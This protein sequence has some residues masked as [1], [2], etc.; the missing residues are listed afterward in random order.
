[1]YRATLGLE[2]GLVAFLVAIFFLS[3]EYHRLF[4]LLVF[5]SA[6]LERIVRAHQVAKTIE[7]PTTTPQYAAR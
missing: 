7:A 5:L 6:A 2:G 1:V 4:W 3:A